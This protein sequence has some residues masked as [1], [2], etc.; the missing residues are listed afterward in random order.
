M[1]K[2]FTLLTMLVLMVSMAQAQLPNGSTAPDFTVTDLQGTQHNL[3]TL[4]DEGKSAVIDLSAAWC[5]P[6]WTYHQLHILE[7]LWQEHGPNGDNTLW[8]SM[9]ESEATNTTAQITGTVAN[10]YRSGF[11]LGDW[12]EGIT[13]PIVD[14]ASVAT[15]YALSFYPT[16]YVIRPDRRTFM[17]YDVVN[18]IEEFVEYYA[19]NTLESDVGIFDLIAGNVFCDEADIIAGFDVMNFGTENLTSFTVEAQTP[20]GGVLSTMDWAGELAPFNQ[21]RVALPAFTLND[22]SFVNYSVSNP[23]GVEDLSELFNEVDSVV[24]TTLPTTGELTLNIRTDFWPEEM[25]WELT[26]S[27]GTVIFSSDDL[28]PLSCDTEYTQSAQISS[29]DCFD[30]TIT[31]SHGDGILNGLVYS[32]SHS[33]G[34]PNGMQNQAMGLLEIVDHEGRVLYN[35]INYG[36]GTTLP[37]EGEG[38]SAVTEV[39]QLES[40]IVYPNPAS[41]DLSIEFSLAETTDLEVAV[42]N[43]LGQRVHVLNNETYTA[44]SN[45]LRL[46]VGNYAEG[47]YLLTFTSNN[48]ISTKRFSVNR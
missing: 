1:L 2:N 44:G 30:F 12:T 46:D 42:F 10:S 22:P 23:N 6:C 34:T 14:D 31:D 16:I 37:I 21:T 7:N 48:G 47:V 36:S 19:L 38:V 35:R 4:L 33:C 25:Y 26:N 5:A 20:D 27:A 32:G 9:I 17:I 13:Y 8:I 3:Y 45:N 43:N 11:T 41:N 15:A 39:D 40:L 24:Y 28:G 29:T 18:P